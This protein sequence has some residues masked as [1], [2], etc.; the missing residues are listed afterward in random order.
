MSYL[1]FMLLIIE[2]S[3]FACFVGDGKLFFKISQML[4]VSICYC[5]NF[6]IFLSFAS[7]SRVDRNTILL[8]RDALWTGKI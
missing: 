3:K 5:Y 6:H 8:Q 2:A 1:K 7:G 4:V